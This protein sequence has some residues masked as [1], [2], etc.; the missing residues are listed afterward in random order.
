MTDNQQ[1][2]RIAAVNPP[3]GGP[4]V[5]LVGAQLGENIGMA[6]RAMLN[7][8]LTEMRLVR[9][10]ETWP[11][12]KAENAAVGAHSVLETARVFETTAEAVADL[13]RLAASTARLRDMIKDVESP[14][15]W[16][17]TA[18]GALAAGERCGI[19]LGPERVATTYKWRKGFGNPLSIRGTIMI[20]R[21]RS[22]SRKSIQTI[23][24]RGGLK[25]ASHSVSRIR[26]TPPPGFPPMISKPK[27]PC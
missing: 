13:H 9:P 22:L 26:K 3:A 19:L 27:P 21:R 6:A 2:E 18:R 7:F 25:A 1:S 14:R 10:R 4:V 11:N 16:A 8:G 15:Q 17:A 12:P 5:V 20:L 24:C 23:L